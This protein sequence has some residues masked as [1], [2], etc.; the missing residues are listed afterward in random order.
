MDADYK[1][2]ATIRLANSAVLS[3]F[4]FLKKYIIS[5]IKQA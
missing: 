3:S 2:K 1:E 4:F 5:I